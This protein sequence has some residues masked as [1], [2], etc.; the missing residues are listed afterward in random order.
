[1]S[2]IT[3]YTQ[4]LKDNNIKYDIVYMDKYGEEETF[5]CEHIYRYINKINRNSPKVLKAMK[6]LLFYPYAVYI[7]NKN[8]YD[9]VI[10]WSEVAIYMFAN[11][12]IRKYK[13][14]YCLN[15][16][17]TNGKIKMY[18]L[19]WFEKC[20]F[21]AAFCTVS[22]DE[23]IP[24]LPKR[25]YIHIHSLNEVILKDVV[26]RTCLRN[27]T[28]ALRIGFIGNIRFMD[29][30]KKL[31]DVFANDNRFIMEY[32]G[33]NADEIGKY[34][35][36]KNINNVVFHGS[37]PVSQ[38]V[39][40]INQI[41]IMNNLYGNEN[42]NLKTALSIKL[43]YALWSRIPIIVSPDTYMERLTTRL[44]IGYVV[45]N[46][47]IEMKESLYDWYMNLD[48][49]KIDTASSTYINKVYSQNELFKMN[50]EHFISNN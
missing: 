34:A 1:M 17:D 8:K 4:V 28:E 2:L 24:M 44:E 14:R 38:S 19:K 16:R 5:E 50:L 25:D 18:P 33:T 48:F 11:F 29:I 23:Y 42:D 47:D 32:F 15:V 21:N 30:N 10:V 43:Y 6:Y 22:S 9:F 35:N 12:L 40:Y 45:N 20:F 13:N 31:I 49:E 7:I 3:L 39:E 46:I 36:E 27:S 41:D 26:P 37:F